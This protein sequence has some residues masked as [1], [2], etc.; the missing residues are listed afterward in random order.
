MRR[1]A[2][3]GTGALGGYYGARLAHA[4][5]E[6]H[7]LLH[8]DFDHVKRH[9]LRVETAEGDYSIA[10]PNIAARAEDLPPCDVAL[11]GL[12]STQNAALATLLPPALKPGGCALVLQNGLGVD[13]AAAAA[14]GADRVVGGLS[15][16]C[17][18]KVGPGHIRHLDYGAVTIA[19][20]EPDP[21]KLPRGITPRLHEIT[22]DFH[23]AGLK[24][25]AA[26][27]LLLTRWQKL[28]W[29][30]PFNGLSVALDA[31]TD[32]MMGQPDVLAW[33][34]AL[35]ADVVRGAGAF[36]REITDSFVQ[37]RLD[38]TYKMRPYLT[39]MKLDFDAVRPMELEAI[40][41]EPLRRAHARGITLPTMQALYWQ[42]SFMASRQA[43]GVR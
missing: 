20:F 21:D 35:M 34:K 32:Q 5:I 16:L 3:I 38:A 1:Y 37:D 8:R 17:S 41:A 30:V 33:I 36:G 24:A 31:T 6:V 2:I 15:F 28:V 14:V 29:N 13:E 4:G 43:S 18:N 10:K 26:A 22:A 7:F 40:F 27:D 42:L 23:A 19:E 39:S 25:T 11:V 12:K 9:G